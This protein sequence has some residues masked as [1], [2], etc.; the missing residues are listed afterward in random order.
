MQDFYLNVHCDFA[1]CVFINTTKEFCT[2]GSILST[3]AGKTKL[4]M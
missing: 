4:E 1:K 3:I 2:L